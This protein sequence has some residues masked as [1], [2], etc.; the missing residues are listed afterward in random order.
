MCRGEERRGRE[1][2]YGRKAESA[3]VI[4]KR[5]EK[6]ETNVGVDVERSVCTKEECWDS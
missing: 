3:A 6:S 1:K 5:V 4:K 2:R